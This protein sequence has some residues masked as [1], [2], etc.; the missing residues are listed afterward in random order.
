MTAPAGL[1]RIVIR[2]AQIVKREEPAQFGVLRVRP[3][4]HA[5][6]GRTL[7]L[8]TERI[9]PRGPRRVSATRWPGA[10]GC[11]STSTSKAPRRA[12]HQPADSHAMNNTH[13]VLPRHEA[14]WG[15]SP[16]RQRTCQRVRFR[17]IAAE[18]SQR[19]PRRHEGR[20]RPPL[21]LRILRVGRTASSRLA[22]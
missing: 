12:L 2:P 11:G 4:I 22:G 7:S 9:K 5:I 14:V 21:E 17:S 20:A 15:S 13:G 18:H 3:S 1:G 10:P 8:C 16:A 6:D 19:A